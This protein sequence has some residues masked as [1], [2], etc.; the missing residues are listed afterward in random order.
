MKLDKRLGVIFISFLLLLSTSTAFSQVS[1]DAALPASETQPVFSTPDSQWVWGEVSMVDTPGK[2]I[3]VKYLDYEN[4]VEKEIIIGVNDT[5]TYE[6]FASIAELK[7]KDTLSIDYSSGPDGSNIA[8]NIIMEKPDDALDL[9]GVPALDPKS[10]GGVM[11]PALPGD[12][13]SPGM[14]PPGENRPADMDG[15]IN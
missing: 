8:K 7:P 3:G 12:V 4:D 2:K 6:N 1:T 13:L 10:E 11:D 5:T 14:L 9:S 15:K